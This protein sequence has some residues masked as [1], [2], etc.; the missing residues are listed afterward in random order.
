MSFFITNFLRKF[1]LKHQKKRIII[2]SMFSVDASENC[3]IYIKFPQC[4]DIRIDSWFTE[5]KSN[6]I[7]SKLGCSENK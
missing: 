7:Q 1:S 4:L 3:L 6:L 2:P 5:N